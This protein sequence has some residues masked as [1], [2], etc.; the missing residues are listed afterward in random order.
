M[1]SPPLNLCKEIYKICRSDRT[2][3]YCR[4]AIVVV[5]IYAALA[6]KTFTFSANANM[7]FCCSFSA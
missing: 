2:L 1:R 6:S 5:D 3:N 4:S 7:V